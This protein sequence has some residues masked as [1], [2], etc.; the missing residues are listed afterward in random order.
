MQAFKTVVITGA[1]KGI[2]FGIMENLIQKHFNVIMAC[3][4]LDLA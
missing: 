2:G 3:R 1:N 4:N